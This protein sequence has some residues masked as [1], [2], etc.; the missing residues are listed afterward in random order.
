MIEEIIEYKKIIEDAI[1][2]LGYASLRYSLFE[3]ENM[4]REE[5]QVRIEYTGKYFEVYATGERASVSGKSE[6]IEFAPAYKEF[7]FKLQL[8]ILRNRRRAR[9][10]EPPEYSCSLWGN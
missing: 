8:V 7:L 4:H 5:Y 3:G 10:G 9:D 1:E 6:Y 2:L